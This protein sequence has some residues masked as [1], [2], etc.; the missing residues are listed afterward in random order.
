MIIFGVIGIFGVIIGVF[1]IGQERKV[2]KV[3]SRSFT[4]CAGSK[5]IFSGSTLP[6]AE[7]DGAIPGFLPTN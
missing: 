6:R 7:R 2:F 1:A 4:H 5:R 3:T